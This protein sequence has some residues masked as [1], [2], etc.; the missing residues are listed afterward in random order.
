ME[1]Q[2]RRW[3]GRLISAG[4]ITLA[5][6]LAVNWTLHRMPNRGRIRVEREAVPQE[7]LGSGDLRIYNSDSSVDVVLVG[8]RVLA[9]LSPKTVAKVRA[10]MEKS[11]ARDTSGLG[12]SIAQMVK[13]QVS[14]AIGM[15]VVYPLAEIRD[16]R[17]EDGHLVIEKTTGATTRL[18]HNTKINGDRETGEFRPEDAQRFIEAVRARKKSTS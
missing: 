9:G 18:F 5:I 14:G 15:H 10:E 12:G 11:A 17:Y 4:L 3:L 8:D 13:K 2:T 1:L 16:V 6:A 7:T